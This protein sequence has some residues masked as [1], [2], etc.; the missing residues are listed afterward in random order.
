[1]PRQLRHE[2]AGGYYHVTAHGNGDAALFVEDDD[3]AFLLSFLGR[4]VKRS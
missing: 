4:I 1:M 2:V 3:F